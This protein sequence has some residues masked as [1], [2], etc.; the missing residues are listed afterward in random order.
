MTQ[1]SPELSHQSQ[2]WLKRQLSYQSVVNWSDCIC[3]GTSGVQDFAF[4]EYDYKLDDLQRSLVHDEVRSKINEAD[5]A[6]AIESLEKW[7]AFVTDAF[8][9]IEYMDSSDILGENH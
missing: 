2:L 3:Q 1:F 5:A 9:D 6:A 7:R 8:D 4:K